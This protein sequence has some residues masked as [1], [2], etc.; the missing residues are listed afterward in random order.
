[1]K[2]FLVDRTKAIATV[3]HIEGW[4]WRYLF[5]FR[6]CNNFIT[7]QSRFCAGVNGSPNNFMD[8]R[9]FKAQQLVSY[10]KPQFIDTNF[11]A[12]SWLQF[13]RGLRF[14]DRSVEKFLHVYVWFDGQIWS[15]HSCHLA[16]T[17][18]STDYSNESNTQRRCFEACKTGN[19]A[20]CWTNFSLY[21]IHLVDLHFFDR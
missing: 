8:F 21:I 19:C 2:L 14:L 10:L 5:H 17:M 13:T 4:V 20:E 18:G 7:F 3:H 11:D 15:I 6:I 16:V 1:M 12:R 9:W